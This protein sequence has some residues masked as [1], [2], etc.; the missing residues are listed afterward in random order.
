MAEIWRFSWET[1]TQSVFSPSDIIR[2]YI[3]AIFRGNISNEIHILAARK[4]ISGLCMYF[5]ACH[6]K[7]YYFDVQVLCLCWPEYGGMCNWPKTHFF[8]K[9]WIAISQKL[10]KLL[11]WNF[12]FC[13]CMSYSTN[14]LIYMHITIISKKWWTYLLWAP[15]PYWKEQNRIAR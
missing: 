15:A 13:V 7:I 12:G 14:S 2:N 9:V 11:I 3:F 6:M 10:T 5:V 8:G 1:R 4:K